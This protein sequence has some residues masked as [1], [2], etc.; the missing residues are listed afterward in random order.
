MRGWM[1]SAR[2][3]SAGWSNHETLRSYNS[4]VSLI[5]LTRIS[6]NPKGTREN[7][8]N[9]FPTDA[10]RAV[11]LNAQNSIIIRLLVTFASFT[12]SPSQI[13]R[14]P[15]KVFENS[16]SGAILHS[17]KIIVAMIGD[18]ILEMTFA[19]SCYMSYRLP[20]GGLKMKSAAN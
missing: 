13:E 2:D 9:A 14:F 19:P 10:A 15:P 1:I 3:C 6:F 11:S 7:A 20:F 12:S 17:I 5:L 16:H 8:G 18:E 4:L